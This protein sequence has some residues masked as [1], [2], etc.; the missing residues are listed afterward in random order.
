MK[1]VSL[2]NG[3]GNQMF[4]F[5]FYLL[6]KNKYNNDIVKLDTSWFQFFDAHNGYELEKI[7]HIEAPYSIQKENVFLFSGFGLFG[8]IKRKFF[9]KRSSE[10]IESKSQQFYFSNDLYGKEGQNNYYL[11][12]WQSYKYFE[13][14]SNLVQR[15][16]TFP[17]LTEN[18]NLELY[19]LIESNKAKTVSIHVR[20]GDYLKNK[21]L[22]ESCNLDYYK[23][24]IKKIEEVVE[25]PLYLIFSNDMNWCKENLKLFNAKYID[26][27][28]S[29]QAYRD[30]QLMSLCA[31][32]IIANSTFSWW[33]AFL[34]SNDNKTVIA[35]KY[36]IDGEAK[37]L[38]PKDW[39]R[40]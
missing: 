26:W 6:I 33:G 30:M 27:N 10:I 8:R 13:S 23:N 18:K 40:I 3:L 38:I 28:T 20:R 21:D 5:A 7:F 32:N 37:D 12:F 39:I 25:E 1:I 31:N 15:N 9:W 17:S 11:G 16:F 36:W 22:L 2:N 19:S 35:P 24:A 14:I 29:H 4:Q 34:N